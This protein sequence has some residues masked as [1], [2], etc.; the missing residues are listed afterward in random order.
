MM[1]KGKRSAQLKPGPVPPVSSLSNEDK[2]NIAHKSEEELLK[3]FWLP[4]WEPEGLKIS[5]PIFDQRIQEFESQLS[6]PNLLLPT[7]DSALS[8]LERQ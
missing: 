7:A 5:W 3:V 1:T 6:K 4:S 8:N 2:I